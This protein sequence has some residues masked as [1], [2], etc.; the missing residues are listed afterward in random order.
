MTRTPDPYD[1]GPRPSADELAYAA[2]HMPELRRSVSGPHILYLWLTI[3]F[4]LGLIVYVIGYALAGS[5]GGE[6]GGLVADLL[7]TLGTALWTGVV[8]ALFVEVLPQ[9]QRRA[10][11]HM[12][13]RYE[14]ALREH[15]AA[16]AGR[17]P[18]DPQNGPA[19]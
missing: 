19:H 11:V 17:A 2:A 7:K 5:A 6:P 1:S 8:L 15:A 16:T 9:S 13:H 18:S 14:I 4:V 10:A 12:L 3:G